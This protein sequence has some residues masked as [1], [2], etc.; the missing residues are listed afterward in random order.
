MEEVRFL[1][2]PCPY[3]GGKLIVWSVTPDCSSGSSGGG[4]TCVD[5]KKDIKSDKLKKTSEVKETHT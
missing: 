1:K 3:C 4:T 2:T 5:C